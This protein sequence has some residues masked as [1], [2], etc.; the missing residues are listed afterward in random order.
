MVKSTPQPANAEGNAMFNDFNN[1]R[2]ATSRKMMLAV[3]ST[4][5]VMDGL[6]SAVDDEVAME[7]FVEAY[8]GEGLG[9]WRLSKPPR[10]EDWNLDLLAVDDDDREERC[11]KETGFRWRGEFVEN[12]N[13]FLALNAA[14]NMM[15]FE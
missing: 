2:N 8:F 12:P 15:L 5:V 9:L 1:L 14:A 10:W 3:D 6:E 7:S 11:E 4:E 13:P